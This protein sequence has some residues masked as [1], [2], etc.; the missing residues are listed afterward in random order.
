[1]MTGYSLIME[2]AT[3]LDTRGY[4]PIDV[5]IDVLDSSGAIMS[6]HTILGLI[7]CRDAGIYVQPIEIPSS[8]WNGRI[9]PLANGCMFRCRYHQSVI[10]A[11]SWPEIRSTYHLVMS[12]L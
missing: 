2:V 8:G 7:G 12:R 10:K 3:F 4:N 5:T 9:T 6:R 1:M 11:S